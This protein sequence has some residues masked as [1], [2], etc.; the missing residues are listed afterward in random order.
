M[1]PKY[2]EYEGMLRML[3]DR[4]YKFVTMEDYIQNFPEGKIVLLR[5][6]IDT[7]IGVAKKFF[8]IEKKLNIK[9]T[10]YFRLGTFDKKLVSSITSYGSEASYHFEEISDFAFANK[11]KT[12][13]EVDK[14]IDI[15]RN[16]F[17]INLEHI[18]RE[19]GINSVTIASHG[20]FVNRYLKI[21]NNYLLTDE[22]RKQCNI[23]VEAYDD[24][25]M[26][27]F[28]YISDAKYPDLYK[29]NF[30]EDIK[31]QQML[32]VLV[33]PRQWTSHF[34]ERLGL[35]LKRFIDGRKYFS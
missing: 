19:Y 15:I 21:I 31:K 13:E 32:Y 28:K 35:D 7:D 22:L 30:N 6:D 2:K 27:R 1:L 18:R 33:H 23:L 20:D 14:N 3:L 8:E 12:K 4:G 26:S 16:N 10:Y 17:I 29:Y 25:L 11:I 34:F 9:C 24:I 5:H